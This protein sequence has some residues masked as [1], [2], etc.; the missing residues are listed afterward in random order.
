MKLCKLGEVL[1]SLSD[2][3]RTA[4]QTALD[5]S[6]KSGG[7]SD[8]KLSYEITEAGFAISHNM[9]NVHRRKVCRCD[10]S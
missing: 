4:L 8:A 3:H 9:V 5:K 2:R 10:W 7:L 1:A 6:Y